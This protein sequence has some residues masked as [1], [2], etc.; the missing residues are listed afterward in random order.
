MKIT[1]RP[2]N[3]AY[4][5]GK[6][7]SNKQA[8][9]KIPEKTDKITISAQEQKTDAQFINV[10]RAQ[11]VNELKA[12][13]TAEKLSDVIGQVSAGSY[14]INTADVAYKMLFV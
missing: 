5:N 6:T 10:L 3:D 8:S 1:M 11:I 4:A 7:V 14:D 2:V 12:G 9:S 13:T